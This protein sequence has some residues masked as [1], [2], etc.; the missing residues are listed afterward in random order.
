MKSFCEYFVLCTDLMIQAKVRVTKTGIRCLEAMVPTGLASMKEFSLNGLHVVVCWLLNS[1][2]TY[3]CISG[4]DLLRQFNMLPHWDKSYRSN[5]LPHPV[6]VY[7]HWANQS[8]HWPCNARCLA[9]QALECQFLSH[10]FDLT[11]K[12]PHSASRNRSLD[13]PL[14]SRR[15]N[16]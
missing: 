16:H 8:Q 3:S 7:W 5:F 14:Q 11:W 10:W 12:N 9:G 15:L 6:T 1:P 4:M 13:L 2:A